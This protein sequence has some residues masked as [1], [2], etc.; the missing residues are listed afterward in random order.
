[1][2]IGKDLTQDES[3]A[4]QARIFEEFAKERLRQNLKFTRRSHGVQ[5]HN[6]FTWL[7][8]I[9]EEFGEV[10]RAMLEL[11]FGRTHNGHIDDRAQLRAHLR[12]ELIEVGA[13]CLALIER[14][15]Q[16]DLSLY[17]EESRMRELQYE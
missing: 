5:H 8:I 1:M 14:L 9:G 6:L 4:L 10:S 15:D 2:Q 17:L 12:K 11:V 3:E 13:C 16:R 7:G